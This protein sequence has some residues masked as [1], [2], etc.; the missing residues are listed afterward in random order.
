MDKTI[1]EQENELIKQYF[2]DNNAL[3]KSLR[4]LFFGLPVTDEEKSVIKEIFKSEELK[5]AFRKNFYSKFGDE[6]VIEKIGDFWAGLD[7]NNIIGSNPQ[8]IKQVMDSRQLAYVWL[9]KSMELLNNPDG[10]KVDLSWDAS[11]LE[12]DPYAIKFLARSKFMNTIASGLN[13]INILANTKAKTQ[14]E[15]LASLK[16]NSSK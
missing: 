13:I 2:K 12:D 9:E 14:E 7:I 5:T 16:K 6:V 8:E 10:E 11:S 3:I 15:V 4:S 1:Q